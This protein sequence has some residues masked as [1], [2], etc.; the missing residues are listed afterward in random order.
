MHHV[1]QRFTLD[2]G[3]MTAVER[4]VAV[5]DVVPGILSAQV[6][7]HL[8]GFEEVVEG[9]RLAEFCLVDILRED[10]ELLTQCRCVDVGNDVVL[11]VEQHAHQTACPAVEDGEAVVAFHGQ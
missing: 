11:V 10:V 7:L 5:A 1:P 6:A 4:A 2:V 8:V 9:H 3:L